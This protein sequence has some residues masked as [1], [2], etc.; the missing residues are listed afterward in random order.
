MKLFKRV[1]ISLFPDE[2]INQPINPAS[3]FISFVSAKQFF[4]VVNRKII[5]NFKLNLF[6][7]SLDSF[8][9]KIW[10]WTNTSIKPKDVDTYYSYWVVANFNW[11]RFFNPSNIWSVVSMVVSVYTRDIF[12][13]YDTKYFINFLLAVYFIVFIFFS[14]LKVFP[15]KNEKDNYNWFIDL[16][17][18]IYKFSCTNSWF[19]YELKKIN[20]LKPKLLK[21]IQVFFMLYNLAKKL[22]KVFED[23]VTDNEY[24][25]ERLFYDEV[26]KNNK[27]T[28]VKDFLKNQN[29]YT[30][31]HR[32]S[33][34]EKKMISFILPA[35][36]LVKYL[37]DAHDSY[38]ISEY[39]VESIYDKEVLDKYMSKF[40]K[41]EDAMESFLL[42]L[43]DYKLFK[44]NYFSWIKKFITWKFRKSGNTEVEDELDELMSSIWEGEEVENVKVPDR[45]KKESAATEKL[46]NFYL[47]FIWG[48]WT[49][50]W[51]TLF[52]KLF[53]RWFLNHLNNDNI[54]S[55]HQDSLFFYGGLLYNY[56][57][58]VFYYK[59]AFENVKA[60][61]EKFSLPYRSS[62][63]QTYSNPYLIKLLNENFFA[64]N[65][66]DIN[67]K[68]IKL[69]IQNKNIIESFKNKFSTNISSIV[70]LNN[71]DFLSYIYSDFLNLIWLEDKN[72]IYSKFEESDISNIKENIYTFDLWLWLNF[73]KLFNDEKFDIKN[74]HSKEAIM[75]ISSLLRD[76]LFWFILY[77]KFLESKEQEIWKD[78]KLNSLKNIYIYDILWISQDYYYLVDYVLNNL[79]DEYEDILIKWI[80][81]DDNVTY[82][83]FWYE[84]W[85]NFIEWK[86]FDKIISDISWEDI[87]WFRWYLKNIS[88]YN[89]RYL[90]PKE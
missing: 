12:K 18:D 15:Y 87:I 58:N 27:K 52:L 42:Y 46:I 59:Y 41:N 54:S 2:I 39:V 16:F 71:K 84:N 6:D 67:Q 40:L 74:T 25:Y 50:K 76:S 77:Y 30:Q 51:D 69:F 11:Y 47:T 13:W 53:R 49:A 45:L 89:K 88:F 85:V 4:S 80:N 86:S 24:Y 66:Q 43:L 90:I 81:I 9:V 3:M 60:G 70:K 36:I 33:T 57:K 14:R 34:T 35:D 68:D 62:F 31:S 1:L 83:N 79:L 44:K 29:L 63:K 73:I 37:F 78:L 23:S 65:L 10:F 48:F 56:S 28:I 72:S 19:K 38:K 64:N 20:E 21:N 17:F 32:V 8:D 26:R 22:N 75:W 7:I 61:K 82:F 55:M 5:E